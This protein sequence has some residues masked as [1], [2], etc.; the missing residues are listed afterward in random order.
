[1]N[2][3]SSIIFADS[4]QAKP[5]ELADKRTLSSIPFGGR[6]RLI[7]FILSSLVNAG[8]SNVAIIPKKN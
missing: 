4:Y 5:N 2:M 8:V 1:M 7:D 3:F 6:F